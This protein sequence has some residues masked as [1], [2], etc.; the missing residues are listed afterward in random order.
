MS[1]VIAYVDGPNLDYSIRA[2]FGHR[3]LWLDLAA[4]VERLRPDDTL[5]RVQYCT[6]LVVKDPAALADQK[7][8]LDALAAHRPR[9]VRTELGHYTVQKP[10]CASC[11]QGYRC[12][13]APP[14]RFRRFEEK[15]TD[16]AIGSR[17]VEDSARGASDVAL[18][19]S[20]D[21]DLVPAVEAARRL[22]PLR[23]IYLALPPGYAKPSP[24]FHSVG[25]FTI[26]EAALRNSQLPET[27]TEAATGAVYSRPA[28]WK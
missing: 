10:R 4:L 16:V 15:R 28:A 13:C 24:H 7:T 25:A 22:D 11:R 14:R 26:N 2:V 5:E 8:H 12:G 19:V 17:L 27:V 1:S 20:A 18:I 23:R 6:T 3:Y 9:D 21:S